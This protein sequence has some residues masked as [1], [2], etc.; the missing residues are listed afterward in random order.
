MKRDITMTSSAEIIADPHGFL[1]AIR[2][3][4]AAPLPA[5]PD[6][7]YAAAAAL[8]DAAA[9]EELIG[10]MVNC[11]K[12]ETG[13]D[14]TIFISQKGYARHAA[15][16]RVAIDPPDSIN[17]ASK[18]VSVA[19]HDGSIVAG[20]GNA[21]SAA[22]LRQVRSFIQIN[23]DVLLDYW[24]VRISTKQLQARLKPI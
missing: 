5:V 6:F 16:I 22:L 20:D 4:D 2:S 18:T 13:V 8:A 17:A 23:R 21:I 11:L 19:I 12:D 1:R 14:N 7:D 10:D 15:R 9:E 3:G 24:D